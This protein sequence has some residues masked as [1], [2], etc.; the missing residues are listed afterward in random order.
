[1]AHTISAPR[2]EHCSTPHL[3][4]RLRN[5]MAWPHLDQRIASGAI[6]L[7]AGAGGLSLGLEAA[8]FA[9]GSSR[10]V[11]GRL[12]HLQGAPPR[13]RGHGGGHLHRRLQGRC[14]AASPWW[15]AGRRASH[16]LSAANGWQPT[17]LATGSPSSYVPWQTCGPTPSSWRT[18]PAWQC[19]PSSRISSPSWARWNSS[20][21]RQPGGCS[22]R[23]T[24]GCPRSVGA[25]SSSARR[26]AAAFQ[27]PRPQLTARSLPRPYAFVRLG[28]RPRGPRGNAN[29][30]IVTYA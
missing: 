23:R 22:R 16:F 15:Q 19:R 14:G 3:F 27:L 25:C 11:P 18:W 17:T 10:A 30:A 29:T 13:G 2:R 1:M 28:R 20:G 4:A 8:G 12:R 7:F 6:D 5:E 21:T 26:A 24:T 9:P